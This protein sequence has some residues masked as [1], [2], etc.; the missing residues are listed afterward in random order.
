MTCLLF[1]DIL[2]RDL[3]KCVIK[4]YIQVKFYDIKVEKRSI[5]IENIYKT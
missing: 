4:T 5:L 2:V 1:Y 3:R